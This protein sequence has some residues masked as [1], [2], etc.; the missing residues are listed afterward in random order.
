MERRRHLVCRQVGIG[1]K[2]FVKTL[3]C[4]DLLTKRN[5]NY[6]DYHIVRVFCC[7]DIAA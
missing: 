6:T 5:E 4:K 3:I 7:L 2:G 1:E